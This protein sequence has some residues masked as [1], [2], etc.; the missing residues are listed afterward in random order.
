M[1]AEWLR[2]SGSISGIW[3]CRSLCWPATN[4]N[5]T[6]QNPPALESLAPGLVYF[7]GDSI[8]G[9]ERAGRN[10]SSR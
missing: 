9:V 10:W 1:D 2:G 6:N 7:W 5:D 3:C 8:W 4:I